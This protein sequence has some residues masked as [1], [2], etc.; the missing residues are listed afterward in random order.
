MYQR[1]SY[2][3][4][5]SSVCLLEETVGHQLRY[6]AD[7]LDQITLF[8]VGQCPQITLAETLSGAPYP[9][10]IPQSTHT[11]APRRITN[12]IPEILDIIVPTTSIL[13]GLGSSPGPKYS[14]VPEI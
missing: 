5:A 13:Q 4:L 12:N 2:K 7:L 14:E 10:L 11:S 1:P 8:K 6:I 3:L 9:V